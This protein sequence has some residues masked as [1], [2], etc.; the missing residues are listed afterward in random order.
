MDA[1]AY[2]AQGRE[3]RTA[4]RFM[5]WAA[6]VV[7]GTISF[8]KAYTTYWGP[9]RR[10]YIAQTLEREKAI[11][12]L[13][14]DGCRD[15]TIRAQLEG[16]NNCERARVTVESSPA[17]LAFYDLMEEID[18][19]Q[20]GVCLALGYNV[21]DSLWGMVKFLIGAAFVLYI[22]G[23]VGMYSAHQGRQVFGQQ[24]LMTMPNG[25]APQYVQYVPMQQ[26]YPS[27]L[28]PP[29]KAGCKDD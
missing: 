8:A 20:K 11:V 12:M 18:F 27:S 28:P 4:R 29:P 3:A 14:T 19:C 13:R 1:A 2:D 23:F 9:Y 10:F 15:A 6:I 5:F 24:L 21:A 22:T 16:Y 17:A 25:Q 26:Q 7:V